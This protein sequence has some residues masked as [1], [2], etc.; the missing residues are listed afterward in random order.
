MSNE[1][2]VE[3]VHARIVEGKDMD[4]ICEELIDHCLAPDAF[5]GAVGCDNMSAIVVGFLH[6]KTKEQWMDK[7]KSTLV[8]SSPAG[9]TGAGATENAAANN[10]SPQAIAIPQLDLK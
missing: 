7:L 2:V 10:S 3:F 6:G 1:Q 5:V 8:L 9:A 4:T